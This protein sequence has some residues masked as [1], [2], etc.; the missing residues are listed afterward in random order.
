[1]HLKSNVLYKQSTN[2]FRIQL[3]IIFLKQKLNSISKIYNLNEN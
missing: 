2:Y 3:K 1:M